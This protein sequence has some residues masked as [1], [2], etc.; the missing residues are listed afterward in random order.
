MRLGTNATTSPPTH[1][2]AGTVKGQLAV[3][4]AG[5]EDVILVALAGEQYRM[6][7]LPPPGSGR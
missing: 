7:R 3:A 4:L 1:A 2:W 6:V 5:L